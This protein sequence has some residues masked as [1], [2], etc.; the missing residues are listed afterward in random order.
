MGHAGHL[1]V[2]DECQFHMATYVGG[3]V[4]STVGE[5]WPSRASREIHAKI[6][7]PAWFTEHN[8]KKGD[9]F[10]CEYRKRFGF[11]EIGC[12]SHY[13]T[14]VFK[15]KRNAKDGCCPWIMLSGHDE[16]AQRSDSPAEAMATHMMM[17]AKWSK[18]KTG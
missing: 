10:D 4:V 5:W 9:A 17:C 14:M 2:G 8:G 6:Y 7:D 16:D 15:A 11:M 3:Y 13:E 18:K 1:C 12:D